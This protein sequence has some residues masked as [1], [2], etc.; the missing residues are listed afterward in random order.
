MT[1][2][3]FEEGFPSWSND[4]KVIYFRSKR[5]GSPSIWRIASDGSGEITRVVEGVA[6]RAM[7][8]LD[9][10]TL[11]FTRGYDASPLWKVPAKG[12]KEQELAGSPKVKVSDW[13]VVSEGI[14]YLDSQDNS[15]PGELPVRLYRP[16][17]GKAETIRWISRDGK[18]GNMTSARDG[19]VLVWTRWYKESD[20][21]RIDG[22]R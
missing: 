11:Y 17:D 2:E 20:I 9:G 15:K 5:S 14:I 7:E 6:L 8:S 16:T 21:M 3:A 12:G 10:K 22:F 13:T 4:G 1:S 19:G 18:V